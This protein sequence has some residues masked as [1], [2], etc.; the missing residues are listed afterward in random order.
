MES[1]DLLVLSALVLGGV[2]AVGCLVL[3]DWFAA[4]TGA[5]VVLLS[6]SLLG[7]PK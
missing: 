3:R 1:L 5:A 2:G 7:L 6:I 4:L